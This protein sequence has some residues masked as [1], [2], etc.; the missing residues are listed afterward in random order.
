[1]IEKGSTNIVRG[2]IGCLKE[3]YKNFPILFFK[4]LE[5][6]LKIFTE[7]QNNLNTQ[8]GMSIKSSRYKVAED[9]LSLFTS[10]YTSENI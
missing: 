1:M 2:M 7:I 6:T 3:M 4:N 10:L 8:S 9:L 5:Q